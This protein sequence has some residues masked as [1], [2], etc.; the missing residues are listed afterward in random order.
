MSKNGMTHAG[1]GMS[2]ASNGHYG[3]NVFAVRDGHEWAVCNGKTFEVSDQTPYS[4]VGP[5]RYY[6][7]DENSR[8]TCVEKMAMMAKELDQEAVSLATSEGNVTTDSDGQK[9]G[10][11]PVTH[12][13]F[14]ITADSPAKVMDGQKYYVCSEKCAAE[15]M[16]TADWHPA[17]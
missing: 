7:A 13:K 11:C 5:A 2:G 1:C 10:V 14:L 17:N 8:V 6:F 3:A 16:Q 12:D 4:D 9:Y 15:L